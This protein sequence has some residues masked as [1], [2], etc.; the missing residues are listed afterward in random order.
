ME[1]YSYIEVLWVNKVNSPFAEL[2]MYYGE[3]SKFHMIWLFPLIVLM[4]VVEFCII[5]PLIWFEK[6]YKGIV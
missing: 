6:L 4:T 1:K 5:G 2:I 3:G